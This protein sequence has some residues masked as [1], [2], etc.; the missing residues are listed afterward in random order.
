MSKGSQRLQAAVRDNDPDNGRCRDL[1]K[2]REMLITT[3][4]GTMLG[5]R[6]DDRL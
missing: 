1:S 3:Q 5:E 6:Q 2:T 4:G